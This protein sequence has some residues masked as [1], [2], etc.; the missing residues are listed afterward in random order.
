MDLTV[1]LPARNEADNLMSVVEEAQEALL[2]A[3][4]DAEI[5]IVDDGSTDATASVAAAL[6][7]PGVRLVTFPVNRGRAHAIAEGFAQA[8]GSAVAVMDS[9]GQYDPGDLAPLLAVL[10]GGADVANGC[11]FDRADTL[12]RRLVSGV[13][14]LVLMRGVVGVRSRDANSGLKMFRTAS[15]PQLGY[16]PSGFRR[17]H[18]YLVAWAEARGL[19][20]VDVPISHRPRTGGRSYIRPGREA[21]NTVLDLM[22]FRRAM[23]RE[24]EPAGRPAES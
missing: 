17:G 11:R 21:R 4:I 12:M 2:R 13:Y 20:V 8:A 19:R 16:D 3:R 9:D 24:P 23:R 5:L 22:A 6:T 7:G 10:A 18:R 1:V 14:N 15:L